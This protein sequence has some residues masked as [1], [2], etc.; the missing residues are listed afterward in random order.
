[1]TDAQKK[2]LA[3][4]LERAKLYR[5][6]AKGRV[7]WNTYEMFKHELLNNNIYGC[8]GLLADALHL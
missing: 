5:K 6:A 1:M 3:S 2:I 7:S 8:E 4:V